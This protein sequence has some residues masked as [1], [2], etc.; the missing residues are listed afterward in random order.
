MPHGTGRGSVRRKT[1]RVRVR[2]VWAAWVW[3]M[4]GRGRLDIAPIPNP[5]PQAADGR[6]PHSGVKLGLLLASYWLL[7]TGCWWLVA[8]AAAALRF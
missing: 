6:R 4:G 8:T 1:A 7:A 5:N 3:V 2:W